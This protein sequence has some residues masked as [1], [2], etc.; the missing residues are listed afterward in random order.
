MVYRFKYVG[1]P[2]D[3]FSG[4][5]VA[6]HFGKT[7]VKDEPVELEDE[8]QKIADRLANHSHF[9]D[10]SDTDA[11][12]EVEAKQKAIEKAEAEKAKQADAQRKQDEKDEA[13]RAKAAAANPDSPAATAPRPPGRVTREP[14][15]DP[16]QGR[17]VE[18][19]TRA[20]DHTQAG[21]TKS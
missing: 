10:M 9:V 6:V 20:E 7:F 1:D 19:R 15:T 12:K 16:F 5:K 13:A 14:V 8:E 2:N 17:P 4:P 21:K 11:T 18:E 3:E